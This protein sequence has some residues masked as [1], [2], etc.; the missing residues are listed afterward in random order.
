MW[1]DIITKAK[2]GKDFYVMRRH[3]I[4]VHENYDNDVERRNTHP[5]LMPKTKKVG[6]M[7]SIDTKILKTA[8]RKNFSFLAT[9]DLTNKN[10]ALKPKSKTKRPRPISLIQRVGKKI[11]STPQPHLR[12]G[13]DSEVFRLCL[14]HG[15]N[16]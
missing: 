12:S 14:T 16:Q 7:S 4:N 10:T 1:S 15:S 11:S 6:K 8:L 9:N 13:L 3:V 2:Q 5:I